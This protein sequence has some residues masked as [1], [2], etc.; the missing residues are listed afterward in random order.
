MKVRCARH[1]PR[2]L[3]VRAWRAWSAM[4]SE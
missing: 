3:A 1:L 4:H 2:M